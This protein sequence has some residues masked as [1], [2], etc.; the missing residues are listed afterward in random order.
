M[1]RRQDCRKG[2]TFREAILM[3][4][5][6][7]IVLHRNISNIQASWTKMG[8]SGIIECLKAGSNDL[9]GTLMNESISRA[10][11]N[12]NGQEL[13]PERMD[14]LIRKAGRIP[15][16]RTTKYGRPDANRCSRSYQAP[17]LSLLQKQN[18]GA[19]KSDLLQ[20]A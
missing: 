15:K 6:A 2:P 3:H 9:G 5:I 1:Y 16:Q 4:A 14:E 19:K 10:A 7:R 11:G 17:P 18:E 12:Q 13:P 8:T 20:K